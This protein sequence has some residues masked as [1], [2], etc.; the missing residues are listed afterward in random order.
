MILAWLI[1]WLLAGGLLA[2]VAGIWNTLW[3]RWISLIA[4]IIHL[5]VLIVI[6]VQYLPQTG[7]TMNSPWII[8]L[9]LPWV[10]QVGISFYLAMDGLSLLLV[11]LTTILGI[12][13]VL[14]SWQSIQER[15]GFFHFNLL[16]VMAA[17]VGVFLALDLFLFY[18]FWEMMLVPLYF[19]I[20]IWGHENRVY[21]TL[22]FFI[23]T[24][25][26]SL[27]MLLGIL[28]LY[29]VHGQNTGVFTFSYTQLL[30]T[31]IDPSIAFWLMLGFFIAFAVKLPMVPFHTWLPDAHTQAPAAG[32]VDLAGLVLK[33]GAYGFLRFVIPLFPQASHD[34]TPVVMWLGV[35]SIFYGALVAFGQ[36]DL[37]RLVAY[38]SISH[39]GFVLI[40]IYAWNPLALQGAVVI[41]LAHG[42]ST[43]ALFIIVGS[44]Y[45]RLHT[46]DFGQM[47]GLWGVMPRMGGVGLF[48]TMASLGLPGLGNFVGEFLVLLGTYQVNIAVAA[49]ATLGFVVSTIYSLWWVQRTF[50][51]PNTEGW[52]TPDLNAREIVM[53]AASVAIL[54]W[55]GLYPQTLLNTA[56]PAL[57]AL[58]R[59]SGQPAV[60]VD[61]ATGHL[62]LPGGDARQP[63]NPSMEAP[64][65][66]R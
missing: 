35:I 15:V 31:T 64:H 66:S 63:V 2:W 26:S 37:K 5:L 59:I 4:L 41:M 24:Q 52:Q 62:I 58:Q 51:G 17:I 11:V 14:V 53:M 1:F 57:E 39:M 33:V 44:L 29:F 3:S 22:K 48:L 8:T 19:L 56:R 18:F 55:I 25:A 49:V 7:T 23:F 30:G 65:D 60:I 46:R 38:T 16:W 9:D 27:L 10:P 28:G 50:F 20:G 61:P 45:A 32:S 6:W 42:I 12:L 34:I 21:A 43:G 54:V 40:G 36:T 13:A 47:G